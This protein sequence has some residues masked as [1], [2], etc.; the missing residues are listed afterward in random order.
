[1]DEA[2]GA[3]DPFAILSEAERS[4]TPVRVLKDGD[5]FAVFDRHGDMVPVP[6]GQHGLYHAGTRFFSG[7]ELLLGSRTPLLLSST[8]SE[9]NV[10]FTADLTNADIR[11]GTRLILPR[12]A[13]HLQ[14]SR[15]LRGSTL[16]ER[17]RVTNHSLQRLDVPVTWRC[18]ADF[19]DIFEVRG[20]ARERRGHGTHRIAEEDAWWRYRGLDGVERTTRVRYTRCPDRVDDHALFYRVPVEPHASETFDLAITCE[21]NGDRRRALSF[22]AAVAT[23]RRRETSD[24][25]RGCRVVTSNSG[26]NRWMQ[27]STADLRMMVTATPFGAYPYA[28]I[29]W[30]ATPFGRDGLLTAWEMLWAAPEAARGVLAFLASTQATEADDA[31]DAQPGKI[32]HEMRTGE[33]AALGEV[34]FGRYYGSADATPLF[35]ALA[36]AYFERTADLGFIDGLWPHLMAALSW[37]DRHGDA[38]GDGFIEYA[39]RS[40]TG[41]TQQGWKDSWDSVFHADGALARAP[42][43]LC[44]VQA[45]AYA[46]WRGAA[47]LAAARGQHADADEFTR[48]A[49]AL[50]SRFDEAF[51]LDELGTYA[52]ALDGDKRPCR[53]RTSNAGH[54]LF[55][56]IAD[57]SRARRVAET[58]LGD[59]SF[60]GWGVRTVAADAARYNP[61]SYHNGSMWPHD[62]AVIAAG[63]SRYGVPAAAVRIFAAIFDLSQ[64]VDLYRLPELVCGFSRRQGDAPTLY[65]VACAP[66]AWSAGAVYLL[67]QSCLGLRIDGGERRVR[68]DHARL[69]DA[70]DWVRIENLAVQHAR[71]DVELTR[72]V[73]D[74]TVTI[75]RRD[76]D[77]EV[78]TRR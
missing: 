51:W 65:P 64:A 59:A 69:P 19:A 56:G 16:V 37:I 24:E 46:A 41:L 53:V 77:V 2:E 31:R 71:I 10:V 32:L 30:F 3:D 54:A 49:Q 4:A 20:T 76:G 29:P 28:G 55:W 11:A 75:L 57:P 78:S 9:D 17:L 5:T 67:L 48:R 23:R 35:V 1:M 21:L 14:R 15:V 45:Y 18:A 36:H 72:R 26:F 74:V 12:G 38:D 66:Q 58:L 70:L 27:R 52:L 68:F 39:R 22:T 47:V 60:S 40:P 8:V 44:E 13:V 63:L 61:M 50:R 34:P 25:A 6:A 43:A 33:M 62:N 73:D 7:F 42:I